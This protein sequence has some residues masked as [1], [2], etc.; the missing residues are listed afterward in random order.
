ME[1]AVLMHLVLWESDAPSF[2]LGGGVSLWNASGT[3][4]EALYQH[5][6]KSENLDQ[7]EPFSFTSYILMQDRAHDETWL[8]WAG[9]YSVISRLCNA[10]VVCTSIPLGM[11]RLLVTKDGF[12]TLCSPSE[13]IYEIN[14]GC[15]FLA[16]DPRTIKVSR[17]SSSLSTVRYPRLNNATLANIKTIWDTSK[18]LHSSD[19]LDPH[20]IR[21]A[22]GYFFYAW[23]S[24]YMEHV[25]L[26]LAIVLES[27]FS[28]SS[29]HELMHQIAFNVSRYIGKT[30]EERREVYAVIKRFYTIRSQVVHGAKAKDTDLY[31]LVPRVFNLCADILKGIL[32]D[33]H[34]AVR[35][36]S[37][38][39]R[40]EL[41]DGWLFGE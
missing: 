40:R 5:L 34:L 31:R 25:C 30:T 1:S 35:F 39:R 18:S 21:N 12:R 32:L 26:N 20:R 22:M 36:C 4:V 16:A 41:L 10:I 29:Q 28:P 38:G 14:P 9:P 33:H 23:R 17:G 3:E 7:G 13:V 8:Y 6:C 37:R 27:L 11:C 19:G 24:Y 2:D 15:E